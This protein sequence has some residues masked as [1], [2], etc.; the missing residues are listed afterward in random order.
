MTKAR[1]DTS[2]CVA[3]SK[4][5]GARCRL[6]VVGGGVCRMHGRNARVK[7]N[8]EARALVARAALVYGPDVE[9]RSPAEAL[10]AAGRSLD[11]GL[12]ALERLAADGGGDPAVFLGIRAAAVESGRIAKLLLDARLDERRLLMTERDQADLAR[13]IETVLAA[14]GLDPWSADV[15]ATVHDALQKLATG[16]M[17]ALVS[18]APT[19]PV[20]ELVAGPKGEA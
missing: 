18:R 17:S 12:Q 20:L 11:F 3:M 1:V 6:R 19:A 2:Q 15:R 16:D 8:Q 4:R 10:M 13:V 9:E 14:W 7:A 5:T